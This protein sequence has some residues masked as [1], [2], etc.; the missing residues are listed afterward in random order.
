MVSMRNSKSDPGL[1]RTGAIS[2]PH[3]GKGESNGVSA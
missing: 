2:L 1:R 3:L